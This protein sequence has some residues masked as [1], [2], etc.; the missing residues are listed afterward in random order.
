VDLIARVT[1]LAPARPLRRHYLQL[2]H[3][4]QEGLLDGQHLRDL[5]D[6][7]QRGVLVVER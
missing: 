1:A 2:V 7:V 6:R 4:A 3:P 5:P